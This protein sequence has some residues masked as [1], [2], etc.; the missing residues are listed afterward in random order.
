MIVQYQKK[1][2]VELS[3][4][5]LNMTNG[6][7]CLWILLHNKKLK[8]NRFYRHY[9]IGDNIVD[10]YCPDA[11]LALFV[12]GEEL[13]TDFGLEADSEVNCYLNSLEINVLRFNSKEI[14]EN[15][16]EVLDKISLELSALSVCRAI[17]SKIDNLK[18]V[19]MN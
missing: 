13:Y 18:D 19:P 11:N 5:R 17:L 16:K 2:N 14:L 12:D 1:Q 4:R 3:D 7:A 15:S 8:G 9:K 10:F 6:E